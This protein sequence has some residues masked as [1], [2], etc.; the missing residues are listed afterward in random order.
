MTP[1]CDYLTPQNLAVVKQHFA[2]IIRYTKNITAAEFD[3]ALALGLTVTLVFEGAAQQALKGHAQGV[4][5]AEA[6]NA[7]AAAIGYDLRSTIYFVAEDPNVVPQSDWNAIGQYFL[8]VKSVSQHP[9]G[10]YGG[11]KLTSALES[12]GLATKKWNVQTWGGIDGSTN[13]E[14]LVGANTFGLSVDVDNVFTADYG[15]HPHPLIKEPIALNFNIPGNVA[16]VLAAPGGGAW[17]LS[18]AGA[19]YAVHT[20]P[21]GPTPPWQG[22]ANGQPF[23]AGRTAATLTKNPANA[24]GYTIT[25]T[26]GETYNFPL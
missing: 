5:D 25:A 13:L 19:I 26:S 24:N 18:T 9:V 3:A 8:G 15:Q 12:F 17:I 21:G 14:Q 22:G 6:A 2:G 20:E 4:A 23:F 11:L 7:A 1:V 10:A 16:D